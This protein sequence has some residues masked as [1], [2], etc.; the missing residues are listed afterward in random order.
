MEALTGIFCEKIY[1]HLEEKSILPDGQKGCRKNLRGTKD[2]LLI[3]KMILRDAKQ[4][5]K[6]LAMAWI[7]YKKA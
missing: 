6:H 5:R 1:Q 4:G 3:D 2:Q 7:D